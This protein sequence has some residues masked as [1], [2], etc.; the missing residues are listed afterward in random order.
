MSL[1]VST[2]DPATMDALPARARMLSGAVVLHPGGLYRDGNLTTA[3]TSPITQLS[4]V[5]G[6]TWRISY[7]GT[8]LRF[9]CNDKRLRWKVTGE[10][11][12]VYADAVE[13]ITGD[14]W[15]V[16]DLG[17]GTQVSLVAPVT[18]QEE[19][20]NDT[21]ACDLD[22]DTTEEERDTNAT[23]NVRESGSASPESN[24][25]TTNRSLFEENVYDM[26]QL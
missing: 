8:E 21:A 19:D 15:A 14:L 2:T 13:D 17:L 5:S 10:E 25:P 11:P 18:R 23:R 1:G 12:E 4:T 6:D 3:E 9:Y 7:T 22:K 26:S 24:E 16:V 20:S